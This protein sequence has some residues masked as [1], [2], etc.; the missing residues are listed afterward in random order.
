MAGHSLSK[1]GV[2]AVMSRPST[3]YFPDSPSASAATASSM[4]WVSASA[5]DRVCD[6]GDGV[7]WPKERKPMCFM[8]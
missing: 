1:T 8:G 3:S 7:Q 6:C 2:N 4:V 5:A